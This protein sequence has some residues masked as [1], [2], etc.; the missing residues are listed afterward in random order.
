MTYTNSGCMWWTHRWTHCTREIWCAALHGVPCVY[1]RD[2]HVG[3]STR[4]SIRIL[5]PYQRPSRGQALG[6]WH[7]C[8][9]QL[10]WWF[11]LVS[12]FSECAYLSLI[13]PT[14]Y[15]K[16]LY[17]L[18]NQIV[19]TTYILYSKCKCNCKCKWSLDENESSGVCFHHPGSSLYCTVD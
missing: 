8:G 19:Y 12:L 4:T 17:Y 7:G 6:C 18:R 2:W 16:Y 15:C 14:W 1:P 13:S 9:A 10:L 5:V 3:C 11:T